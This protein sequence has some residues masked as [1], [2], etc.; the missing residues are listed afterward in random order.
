VKQK[1]AGY[2]GEQLKVLKDYIESD[3]YREVKK[4]GIVSKIDQLEDSYSRDGR[5][6]VVRQNNV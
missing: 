6:R 1:L 4:Q 2:C 5:V 3:T